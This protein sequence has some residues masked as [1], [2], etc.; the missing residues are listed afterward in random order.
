MKLRYCYLALIFTFLLGCR[1]GFIALWKIPEPDPV[2]IFPYRVS[3]L[4]PQDRDRLQKGIRV[5]TMEDLETSE[6]QPTM[7]YENIR[8]LCTALQEE[9]A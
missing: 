3:S 9:T 6:T 4:P 5:G 8:A 1:D 7:I 2:Y